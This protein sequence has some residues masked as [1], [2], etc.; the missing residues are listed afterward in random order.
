MPRV[1]RIINRLNLGGPTYNVAYLTKHLA[2]EFETLLVSGM[3]DESEASSEFIIE[4][5]GI[6]PR[7]ISEM[8]RELNP[9]KDRA[10]YDKIRSIIREFKPDIV[11]THAAKAGAVGRLAAYHE[12]VP[13][14]LH[15]FHG[16][17]F[18]SYFSPLKTRVFLEIERYLA[19]RSTGIVAISHIQKK[20]LSEEFKIAAPGKFEV[21]NLGFDLDRFAENTEEK[22]RNFR[23]RWGIED[24]EIAV[25]IIGRLVPVKNH[26]L[27]LDAVKQLLE[28]SQKP[29]KIFIIGDGEQSEE[30]KAYAQS[31]QIPYDTPESSSY[32]APLVFT[33][34]IKE[35][36]IACAGLDLICLTSNNEGTPVSLIE[37]QAAGKAIVTTDT[38]GIRDIVKVGESA[39]ISA[40]RDVQGFAN[41]LI[42]L[43]EN[44]DEREAFS[45]KGRDF[46]FQQFSYHRLVDDMARYYRHLLKKC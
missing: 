36:D 1:L 8:Y 33:S 31:L 4:K 42:R 12:K 38:G 14:I 35:V 11:H 32:K 5:L 21:I 2:P 40:P 28:R 37:A 45:R 3:I 43:V 29:L 22:R 23:T 7:Y 44:D 25:G 20:E 19:K 10:A 46:V 34:W 9:L 17:V 41:N 15:T 24:H 16:H 26:H 27:F 6:E 18:H 30:I 39:L 13:V